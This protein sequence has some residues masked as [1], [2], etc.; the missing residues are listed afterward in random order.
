[1]TTTS[2]KTQSVGGSTDSVLSEV[3]RMLVQ[4]N[5]SQQKPVAAPNSNDEAFA[6]YS[7]R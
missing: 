4:V 1:V 6:N 7:K 5:A 2:L 3:A